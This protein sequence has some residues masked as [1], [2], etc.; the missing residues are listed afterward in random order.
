MYLEPILTFRLSVAFFQKKRRIWGGVSV[1]TSVLQTCQREFI[2]T[3]LN[4]ESHG[5]SF[6]R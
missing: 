2:Q 6:V 4:V 1:L 3:L 5:D